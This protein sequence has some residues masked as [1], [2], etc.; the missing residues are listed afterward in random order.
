MNRR[1]FTQ[2]LV[3]SGVWWSTNEKK[4]IKPGNYLKAGD[5][6]GLICPA[7]PIQQERIDR[8]LANLK[9]LGL[10]P[11]LGKFILQ[12]NG[13]LAGNQ[14]ERLADLHD[15]YRDESIKGIWCIRGGFGCTHLLP[16]LDYKLIQKNQKILLGFSDVTAFHCALQSKLN[17]SNLHSPVASSEMTPYTLEQFK[18]IAFG[19]SSQLV[20]IGT[21]TENDEMFNQGKTVFERYVIHQGQAHGVLW[22]GNL[23]L[24]SALCGTPYIKI[25]RD[26]ILFI[27]DIEEAP[28]RVDRMITQL[29]Q[30]LPLRLLRGVI[31]GVFEGCEKKPEATTQSLKEVMMDRFS[32]LSIPVMYGFPFGHIANQCTFPFGAE[33]IMDTSNFS[34]TIKLP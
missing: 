32:K 11:V 18:K 21:C 14:T 10:E 17:Q 26:F 3:G 24:L 31:L 16:D 34:L 15:M 30:V 28:Y 1:L 23:S 27:E 12:Q 5:R 25:D 19:Q 20:S 2:T 6:I 33:V 22:G 9:V 7:S 4:R 13:Y 29:L 8:S